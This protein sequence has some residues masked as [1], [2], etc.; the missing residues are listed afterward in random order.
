MKVR[1]PENGDDL[2]DSGQS[3]NRGSLFCFLRLEKPDFEELRFLQF[4]K[5][6]DAFGQCV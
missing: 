4:A 2:F 6:A 5:R 1:L 3:L